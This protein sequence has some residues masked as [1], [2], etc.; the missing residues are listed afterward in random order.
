MTT[1]TPHTDLDAL[2]ANTYVDGVYSLYNPQLGVTRSGKPFLKCLLRD[3]T[4]E[5]A[6]RP[7]SFDE[8]HFA[9]LESAGF[10][11]VAGHSQLYNGQVQVII[12]QIRPVEVSEQEMAALMP[13]TEH[14]IGAMYAEVGALL[15]TLEHPAIKALADAYLGDDDLMQGFR[16]APAAVSVHHAWIGGLL[17]HTLQTMKLADR[18]LPLYPQL[19]RDLVLMGLFLHDLGKAMELT[20]TQG[21]N[22]SR[23][24]NLVGH[25]VRG[26]IWLQVKAAVAAKQ[27]SHRVPPDALRV[28]MHIILSHHG[29]PEFGAA[30]IPSTPEA[31]FVAMLDNLDA[32]TQIALTAA[33]RDSAA[34]IG[35]FTDKIWA[36][37]TRIYRPDPL[38]ESTGDGP[39]GND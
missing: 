37:G 33:A 38:G 14:D 11:W 34:E 6:A 17:E 13:T 32:K 2:A 22:Y 12:E 1:T 19:N 26:A 3:A 9:E 4:G 23:D 15:A 24:G 39:A 21:F 7:W 5:V 10:V 16:Q 35:E 20:W 31:V 8:T 30:K 36:L 27:S 28:L 25:V 29:L 18:M